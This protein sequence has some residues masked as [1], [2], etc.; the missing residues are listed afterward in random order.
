MNYTQD[1][2]R[3]YARRLDRQNESVARIVD[4]MRRGATLHLHHTQIGGCWWLSTGRAVAAKTARQVT[5]S[6]LV[7]PAHNA[8]FADAP[9]QSFRYRFSK[10]AS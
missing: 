1:T 4:A 3:R 2:R 8:L 10:P 5:L 6:P 9:S 7:V